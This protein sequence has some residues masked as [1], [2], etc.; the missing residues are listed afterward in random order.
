MNMIRNMNTRSLRPQTFQWLLEQGFNPS[1][2]AYPARYQDTPLILASRRGREDVVSDLLTLSA[3]EIA[4]NHR[5][6]DGTNALWAAI[7]ADSFPIAEKLLTAGIDLD[8]INENGATALMYASSA[9]KTEWVKFLL[10]NGADT[11][12]ETPEGFT[13]LDLASSV[14]CL[15]LLRPARKTA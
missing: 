6:M 2:P 5:N 9:G 12:A 3:E 15:R 13:A 1:C 14:G 7:V 10:E 8:N 4:L 11:T